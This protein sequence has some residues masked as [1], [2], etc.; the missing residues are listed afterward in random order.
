[1]SFSM[2]YKKNGIF[3]RIDEP[4]IF[5][6]EGAEILDFTFYFGSFNPHDTLKPVSDPE[7]KLSLID[8]IKKW[9][10]NT[11]YYTGTI[12][13]PSVSNGLMYKCKATGTSG[14]SEQQWPTDSGVCIF[15]KNIT[16]MNLGARLTPDD[17]KI[18]LSKAAL[19]KAQAGGSISFGASLTGGELI[20]IYFRVRNTD[21]TVRYDEGG[22]NICLELNHTILTTLH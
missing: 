13:E 7:I 12:I 20:P 11:E 3:M 9:Q 21:K 17:V 6:F 18:A 19:N 14:H 15:D 8:N 5:R 10:P 2:Y 16:W 4:I 1:M 22:S